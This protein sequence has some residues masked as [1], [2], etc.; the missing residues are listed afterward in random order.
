MV[1][2]AADTKGVF[3]ASDVASLGVS[4][5]YLNYLAR[6]GDL[7]RVGRGL[8]TRPDHSPTEHHSL[9]AVA[10]HTPGSVVCLLS[11]LQF[12]AIG[13]Q[14]PHAVWLAIRNKA[15]VPH[16]PT[17]PVQVVRMSP[18]SLAGGVETH[19]LEGVPVRIFSAAKTI[20]DCFKFRSTVGLDVAL[21]ALKEG[22]AA[23][24]VSPAEIY[25]FAVIDR[26]WE[27]MQP[28]LEAVQ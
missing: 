10:A 8:F 23:R 24:K 14:M 21:E 15:R 25:P 13:T 22:L 12:H 1:L 28:Y 6:R 2:S 17:M 27:V 11:A 7:R 4:A 19:Y 16:V 26:V 9:V 20:A 5:Q 18:A 3:R